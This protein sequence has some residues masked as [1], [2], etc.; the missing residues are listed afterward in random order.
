[1]SIEGRAPT[2]PRF[3]PEQGF[4]SSAQLVERYAQMVPEADV[5]GIGWYIALGYYKLAVISEGI[6]A[7]YLM[8]QTV[9][10]GFDHMGA[11]VPNLIDRAAQALTR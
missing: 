6:H 9:G 4:L 8:G 7:R 2:A 3:G 11:S 5:S 1:L 10:E